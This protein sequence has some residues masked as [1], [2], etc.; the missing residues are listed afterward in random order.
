[1]GGY[2]SEEDAPDEDEPVAPPRA[3]R[4]LWECLSQLITHDSCVFLRR[5]EQE[6]TSNGTNSYLITSTHTSDLEASR[7][8]GFMVM[9]RMSMSRALNE[10]KQPVDLRR[11][12]E[13]RLQGCTY[14]QFFSA[15]R[16]VRNQSVAGFDLRF[17]GNCA[18]PS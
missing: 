7:S 15:C 5:L 17:A 6:A 3:F 2:E 1:M 14:L 11:T 13:Q 12:A 18:V 4:I 8:N 9:L 16:Q 10:L